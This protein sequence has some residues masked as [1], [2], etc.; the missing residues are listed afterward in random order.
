MPGSEVVGIIRAVIEWAALGIEILGASVIV[1]GVL[2]VA[3]TRGAVRYL[4]RLDKPGAYESYKHEM[5]RSLLLG[6]E[7]LVAG[8][9][10][11]TVALEPTL[12]N[13]AVL[14]LLV[15]I[16]TFL[17]WSL[18]V[19]IEGRWPWQARGER[20]AAVETSEKMTGAHGTV[21]VLDPRKGLP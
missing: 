16:R 10:V 9:V 12:N 2:R 7:F 18:A 13:V 6:L 14:G 8:D 15:L 3:I 4:S 5:G 19:E 1:A 11:R 20:E 21:E 17:G